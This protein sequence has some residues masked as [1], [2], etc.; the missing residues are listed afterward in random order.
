MDNKYICTVIDIA[1]K[2]MLAWFV[3]ST[4]RYF[5]YG[6][7]IEELRMLPRMLNDGQI[8]WFIY[9]LIKVPIASIGTFIIMPLLLKGNIWGLILGIL[10]WVMGYPTNPLWFIVPYEIQ[11]GTDGQAV[12]L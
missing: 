2:I 5:Y 10:H 11:V 8:F 6:R 4:I 7:F 12:I 9:D 3:F 1:G